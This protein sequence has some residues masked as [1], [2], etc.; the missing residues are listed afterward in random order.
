MKSNFTEIIFVL[1]RSGS[2]S[3]LVDDV[4][5]GFNSIIDSQRKIDGIATV[6]LVLFDDKYEVLYSAKDINDIPP[7]TVKQYSPR[8]LTALL[9]AVGKTI[10]DEGLRLSNMTE[11]ERP[12]KVLFIINTDGF[13]NASREYTKQRICEMVTHQRE[14][15][16]WEFLFLGADID[17]FGA[18]HE[19]GISE[20]NTAKYS[21]SSDGILLGCYAM[22][23]FITSKR[24]R[25]SSKDWKKCL[26]ENN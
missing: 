11:D 8:G 3:P 14:K 17:A 16:S 15:Y 23:S 18:A 13:E 26:E 25:K 12:S 5:G 22:D 6:T 4:V 7:L 20:A 19:L 9:D 2:M 10:D 1:D 24:M 21:H